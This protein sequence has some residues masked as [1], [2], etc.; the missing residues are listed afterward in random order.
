MI[1]IS[2]QLDEIK[3]QLYKNDVY[4]A[5]IA[6]CI[7]ALNGKFTLATIPTGSGKTFIIGLLYQ[8]YKQEEDK[9]VTT[10]APS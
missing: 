8:Y 5:T 2:T 3:G 4:Q 1:K 10:V 7:I 9:S 6:A